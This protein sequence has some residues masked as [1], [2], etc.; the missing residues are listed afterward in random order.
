MTVLTY[1]VISLIAFLYEISHNANL[2]RRVISLSV[3]H[4]PIS[5]YHHMYA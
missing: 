5:M 4:W 3:D 2:T 1:N